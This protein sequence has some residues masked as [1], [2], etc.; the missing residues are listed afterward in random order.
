MFN[1]QDD[2]FDNNKLTNS[3][4]ITVNRGPSPDNE[5]ANKE[6]IDDSTREGILVR[7]N[8]TLQN[9]L[10]VPVGNDK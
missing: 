9:Y 10:K 4:S 7:F 3:D 2:E 1:D 5:L 8:Q 6:F